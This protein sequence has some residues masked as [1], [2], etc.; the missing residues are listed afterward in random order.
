MSHR[1]LMSHFR[2]QIRFRFRIR[3]RFRVNFRLRLRVTSGELPLFTGYKLEIFK[4]TRD[5]QIQIDSDGP[6]CS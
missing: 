4:G 3:I 1:F 6:E 5:L 2:I